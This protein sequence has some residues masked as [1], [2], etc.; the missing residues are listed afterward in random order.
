MVELVEGFMKEH[1][2]N[3]AKVASTLVRDGKPMS[4]QGFFKMVKN[5]SLRV[6][7]LMEVLDAQDAEIKI[8]NRRKES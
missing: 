6:T 5:G 1:G 2:L 4:R 3:Y 8:E 7:T